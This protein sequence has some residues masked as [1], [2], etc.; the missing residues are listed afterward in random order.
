MTEIYWLL[1]V[2]TGVL[3]S[4]MTLVYLKGMKR[5]TWWVMK[6]KSNRIKKRDKR[7]KSKWGI[8]VRRIVREYLKELQK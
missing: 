3:S 6:L 2:A 1:I 4:V 8:V 7:F 5:I